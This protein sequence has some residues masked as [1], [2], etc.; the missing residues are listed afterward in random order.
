MK[1]DEFN[2]I[3]NAE[4]SGLTLTTKLTNITC[5][6]CGKRIYLDDSVVLTTYPCQ[7]SYIC[8]CGWYGYSHIKWQPGMGSQDEQVH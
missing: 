5:P 1:W 8:E 6:K 2:G 4:L 3:E 7:F